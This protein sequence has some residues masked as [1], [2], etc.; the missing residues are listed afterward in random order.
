M[1]INLYC[2]S[3]S[4]HVESSATVINPN[5]IMISRG[6]KIVG[7]VSATY[8]FSKLPPEYHLDALQI[9]QSSSVELIASTRV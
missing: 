7:K 6:G 3:G 2:D 1:S 4:I 9:I 8:D 5:A